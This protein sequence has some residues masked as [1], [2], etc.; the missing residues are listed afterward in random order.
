MTRTSTMTKPAETAPSTPR[1]HSSAEVRIALPTR[2]LLGVVAAAALVMAGIWSAGAAL[3]IGGGGDASFISGLVGAGAV[4]VV[5]FAGVLIM[6]PWK[7]RAVPDWMTM[8]LAATVFRLL[9]TPVLV[10]LLYSAA[11]AGGEW[12]AVKPLVLSVAAT[13]F[14]TLLA[15]AAIL[16]SHMKRSFP[17]A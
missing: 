4:G 15:E 6:T 3:G 8:W 10:Y 11:S 1:S 13:Y 7:R 2:Q 12:L 16:A 14:V 17:S 9:V 5:A